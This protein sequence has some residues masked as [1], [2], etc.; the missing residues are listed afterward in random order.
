MQ[1]I[2]KIC[3]MRGR[4]IAPEENEL[5]LSVHEERAWISLERL[6]NPSP[7]VN[8]PGDLLLDKQKMKARS[9]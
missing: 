8:F 4:H 7:E 5:P 9:A 6:L 3:R 1:N 2:S